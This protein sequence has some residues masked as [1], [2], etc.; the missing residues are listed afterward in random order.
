MKKNEPPIPVRSVVILPRPL[1]WISVGV[2]SALALGCVGLIVWGLVFAEGRD[3]RWGAAGG[4]LGGLIGCAGGLFGTLRDWH[5]R[6][7]ATQLLRHVRH[8]APLP[9]Y[10]RAFWP[11]LALFVAG[12]AA[13]CVW[14][15]RA[16]WQGV[17]QPAGM[18]AF[19][20]GG[21]ELIRRHTTRQAR[22]LFVLYVDGT[23]AAE[24]RAAIDDARAKDPA[25]DAEVHAWQRV[26][27]QVQQLA[28][29]P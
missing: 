11:A 27:E 25:F 14:H 22:T 24:D 28:R 15:E 19:L 10:R 21:M 16:I 7:P 12:V 5:R 23:L 8:D 3:A 18:I 9:F 26:G 4:G 20:S 6:L 13:G 1:M 29:E 2:C 17:V